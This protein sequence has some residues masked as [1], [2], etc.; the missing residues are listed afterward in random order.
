MRSLTNRLLVAT[1]GILFAGGVAA[2]EE[3]ILNV[4]NWSD[5][6]AEDTI[7]NFEKADRH[8]K[9]TTTYL[10]LMRCWRPSCWRA[11]AVMT[12]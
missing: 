6:I 12:W 11:T 2:A 9:S 8:S 1:L 5:Y 4:Y 7:T 3:K 10:T